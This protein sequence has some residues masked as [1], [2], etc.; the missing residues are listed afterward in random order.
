MITGIRAPGEGG[1]YDHRGPDPLHQPRRH[2][3]AQVRRQPAHRGRHDEQAQAGGERLP[4]LDAIADRAGG[5]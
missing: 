4:G 3:N 1:R 5:Q 2:Q